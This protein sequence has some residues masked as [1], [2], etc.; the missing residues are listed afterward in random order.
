[1]AAIQK[2]PFGSPPR[3]RSSPLSQQREIAAQAVE[4]GAH[5]F[6]IDEKLASAGPVLRE[7]ANALVYH[8]VTGKQVRKQQLKSVR[9]S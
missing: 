9:G 6:C 1:M 2:P 7:I 8:L 3:H 5:F 4:A